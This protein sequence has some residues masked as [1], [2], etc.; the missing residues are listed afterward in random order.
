MATATVQAASTARPPRWLVIG[1]VLGLLLLAEILIAI[2]VPRATPSARATYPFQEAGLALHILL[3][4]GLLFSAVFLQERDPVLSAFLVAL[5]LAP[6]IRIFSLSMP[7][8]WGIEATDTLPWLAVVSVPLLTSV[9]AVAY[10]Q[11]MRPRDLGLAFDPW[12][13][14]LVQAG[15][16][17][18]GIPL[19][20]VEYEI[21]KPDAWIASAALAPILAGGLVIF[22]A[23]G[24]SEELI[25]RGI[26]LRR[27]IE[28][29]GEYPGILFVTLV[30]TSLHVFFR[31][32][33][34]LAFVFLVGLFYA[35]VVVRTKSLWG[36]I[37]SHTLGNVV[38]YLLAPVVFG[39]VA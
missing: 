16:G 21:L 19:G 36:A 28:S 25:F 1:L 24:M 9:A 30:F 39:L 32:G 11:R 38:L 4:F 3:V 12:R 15:I 34:D 27:A 31:N 23:T 13:K 37:T 8:Y 10:V 18:T 17:L 14:A 6:L 20:F 7:R 2:E 33:Y 22:F 5:S 29:L 26:M 35:L